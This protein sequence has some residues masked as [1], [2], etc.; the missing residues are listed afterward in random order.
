[1]TKHYIADEDDA[2]CLCH[3]CNTPIAED[4]IEYTAECNNR[5]YYFCSY[6]CMFEW[7]LGE[8]GEPPQDFL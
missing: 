2:P 8:L 7:N 6:G 3:Y 5:E 1:M 4:D